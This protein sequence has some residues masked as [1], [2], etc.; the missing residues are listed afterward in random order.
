MPKNPSDVRVPQ[1]PQSHTYVCSFCDF[2]TTSA[3]EM[4]NHHARE[5]RFPAPLIR[6]RRL[7]DTEELLAD[8]LTS[9]LKPIAAEK[10][11]VQPCPHPSEYLRSEE[12]DIYCDLC[13]ERPVMGEKSMRTDRSG[14]RV[15][16]LVFGALAVSVLAP[17]M[18]A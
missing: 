2:T 17:A 16:L 18:W 3:G 5:H 7:I 14:E 11:R 12:G 10:V 1:S 8:H 4:A 13:G 9:L 15:N 6:D